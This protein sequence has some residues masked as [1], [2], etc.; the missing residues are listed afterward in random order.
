[1]RIR[2]IVAN[3]NEKRDPKFADRPMPDPDKFVAGVRAAV[4]ER[5]SKSPS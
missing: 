2:T 4:L 1:V 3:L 5:L